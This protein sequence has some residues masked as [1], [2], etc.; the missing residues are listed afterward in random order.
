MKTSVGVRIALPIQMD[1]FIRTRLKENNKWLNG[2]KYFRGFSCKM[3]N[4]NEDEPCI[5]SGPHNMVRHIMVDEAGLVTQTRLEAMVWPGHGQAS[6]KGKAGALNAPSSKIQWPWSILSIDVRVVSC[7]VPSFVWKGGDYIRYLDT[8][9][10]QSV[11]IAS[12]RA[13]NFTFQ[14]T[15]LDRLSVFWRILDQ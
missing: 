2:V 13:L 3:K 14:L 6:L 5:L 9:V 1:K 10:P 12:R 11:Y 4:E 15:R 7:I 8:P